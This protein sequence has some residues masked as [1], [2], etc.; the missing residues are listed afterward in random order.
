MTDYLCGKPTIEKQ[1]RDA[2]KLKRRIR[3]SVTCFAT[4]ALFVRGWYLTEDF[5]KE[6]RNYRESLSASV[7]E[8]ETRTSHTTCSASNVVNAG[9]LF[10]L[11]IGKHCK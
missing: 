3:W 6:S 11:N 10:D 2:A 5:N 9:L 4:A 8:P 7:E 1:A